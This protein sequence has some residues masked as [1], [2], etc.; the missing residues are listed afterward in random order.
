M[1]GSGFRKKGVTNTFTYIET[2]ADKPAGAVICP[3]DCRICCRCQNHGRDTAV[4]HH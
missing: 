1:N 4:V 2:E 3:G